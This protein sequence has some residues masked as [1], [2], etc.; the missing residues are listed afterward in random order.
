M[1]RETSESSPT[2]APK[3][4]ACAFVF[5]PSPL[6]TVTIEAAPNGG[7]EL[8]IHPGGQGFWIG[9]MASIL[10]MDV[11]L[12]GPFG[13]EPG[14]ILVDLIGREGLTV[15]PVHTASD[16]GSYVHDRRG[17]ERK[18]VVEVPP[19]T[20][21]RHETDD[22]FSASLAAAMSSDVAVLGG[23]HCD[24]AIPAELYSR[25]CSDLAALKIPVLA[26][27]SGPTLTASLE[28]GLTL[29]KVS[30]E[31]LIEDG[32]APSDDLDDLVSTMKSLHEEGAETVVVS[33]AAEPAIALHDG[34]VWEVEAPPVQTVDHH[35]AGDSMTAGLAVAY[36]AGRPF[37]DALRLGAAAGAVNV[38]RRGLATGNSRAVEKMAENVQ[39]RRLDRG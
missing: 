20:L 16:N 36:A 27:L 26:D 22:L 33:R 23:P 31:D 5:A 8:H 38:T 13:G 4:G 37:E 12:C 10:G 32:R 21:T 2:T 9:R 3:S 25:L 11:H 24:E 28:G 1:E 35:G 39:V 15:H 19:P 30:H 29:L 6:L 17:G 18:E 34:V 14:G 7:T